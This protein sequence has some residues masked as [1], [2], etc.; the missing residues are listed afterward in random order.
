[1]QVLNIDFLYNH[2][3]DQAPDA[4]ASGDRGFRGCSCSGWWNHRTL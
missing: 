1:M 3:K 2:K 4:K